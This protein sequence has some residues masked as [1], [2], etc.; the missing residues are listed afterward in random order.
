MI[1]HHAA[2]TGHPRIRLESARPETERQPERVDGVLGSVGPGTSVGEGDRHL[3]QGRMTL[4]HVAS[5]CALPMLVRVFNLSGSEVVF[6]LVAGLVVLGPER[7]PGVIR[8][9]GRTYG[10]LR[11]MARSFEAE[12]KGTFEEP[13][14]DLRAVARDISSGFGAVDNEPSPP[15]RPEKSVLPDAAGPS[16]A[17]AGDAEGGE[18][19]DGNRT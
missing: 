7:L 2:V 8:G 9:I 11:R 13:V 5:L 4:A 16:A 1:E 14:R 6:L 10:E 12:M 15:M 3:E 19:T 18:A 17:P